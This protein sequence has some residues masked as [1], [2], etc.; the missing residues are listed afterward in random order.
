MTTTRT[1]RREQK[2]RKRKKTFE[3]PAYA[4]HRSTD[5]VRW[6][7]DVRRRHGWE[8]FGFPE[9][10]YPWDTAMRMLREHIGTF[11]VD[12][13][14]TAVSLVW[15]ALNYRVDRERGFTQ[16]LQRHNELVRMRGTEME[17]ILQDQRSCVR[18]EFKPREGC[19]GG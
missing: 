11:A 7:A 3:S 15:G 4:G 9:Q 8:T 16:V 13:L 6:L 5:R 10:L 1:I 17:F 19:R 12:G 18:L 2:A 14:H